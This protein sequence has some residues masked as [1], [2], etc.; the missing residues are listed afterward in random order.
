VILKR[1]QSGSKGALNK[2]FG[3]VESS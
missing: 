1:D 2:E 3:V